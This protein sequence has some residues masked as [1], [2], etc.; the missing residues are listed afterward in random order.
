MKKLL[1]SGLCLLLLAGCGSSETKTNKKVCSFKEE[2]ATMEVAMTAEGDKI[3]V[4]DIKMTMNGKDLGMDFDAITD[5][6]KKMVTDAMKEQFKDMKG[7]DVNAAIKEKE[8]VMTMKMDL[9]KLDKKALEALGIEDD[10]DDSRSLKATVK[11]ME[12]EGATCK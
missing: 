2:G 11:D 1:L 4:M 12:D 9:D 10:I 6:Q 7:L 8:I 5:E 3:N